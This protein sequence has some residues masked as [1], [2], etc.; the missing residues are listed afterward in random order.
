[1]K[2]RLESSEAEN[3]FLKDKVRD[4]LGE[5]AKKDTSGD[6]KLLQSTSAE[7]SNTNDSEELAR[8]KQRL[9]SL[10]E[11]LGQLQAKSTQQ[12]EELALYQTAGRDTMDHFGSSSA[13]SYD[14]LSRQHKRLKN[15][16]A[17]LQTKYAHGIEQEQQ[18]QE[19]V[20]NTIC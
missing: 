20:A 8:A 3:G 4:L 19:Q 18:L 15:D 9:A 1:M 17:A 5:V 16:L 7:E 10:T 12:A 11:E 14:V 6:P 2:R 13:P